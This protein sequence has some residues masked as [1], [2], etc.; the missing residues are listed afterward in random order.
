MVT[1][2]GDTSGFAPVAGDDL[3]AVNGGAA[4]ATSV[5]LIGG[6][7][8]TVVGLVAAGILIYQYVNRKSK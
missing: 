3:Q 6:P 4:A 5:T 7:V 8:G 2:Y 1:S